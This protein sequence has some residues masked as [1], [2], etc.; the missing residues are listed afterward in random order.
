MNISDDAWTELVISDGDLALTPLRS[1]DGVAVL[2]GEDEQIQRWY[3]DGI[4]TAETVGASLQKAEAQWR[5]GGPISN[6]GIRH[7][8]DRVL[9]GTLDVQLAMDFTRDGQA[10]IAYGL[11]QP[12]RGKGLA[13]RAVHLAMRFLVDH[14][15]AREAMIQTDPDNTASAAVA[16][17]AGFTL[18]AR[19]GAD[20]PCD[21]YERSLPGR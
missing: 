13:T 21:R 14:T 8:A 5:D 9:I 12:W 17:R 18:V 1:E 15:S 16:L 19:A 2:A 3:S 11:H 4:S 10:N 7:G 6:F 20:Q